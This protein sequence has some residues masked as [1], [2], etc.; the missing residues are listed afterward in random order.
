M[1]VPSSIDFEILKKKKSLSSLQ[2]SN[3][4]YDK[5]IQVTKSCY[6]TKFG[7]ETKRKQGIN[8]E[9]VKE[10]TVK[11]SHF[12]NFF[13]FWRLILITRKKK[14]DLILRVV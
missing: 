5:I 12:F 3:S 10:K 9:I 11:G 6:G 4:F 13:F 2:D 8:Q 1:W 14:I 7:R